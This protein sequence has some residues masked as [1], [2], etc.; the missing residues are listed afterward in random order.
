VEPLRDSPSLLT[1]V[2]GWELD[3]SL[4]STEFPKEAE[5]LFDSLKSAFKLVVVLLK[6]VDA[7]VVRGRVE[8]ER[9]SLEQARKDDGAPDTR[10]DEHSENDEGNERIHVL[11][12]SIRFGLW[13]KGIDTES[14]FC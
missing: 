5:F 10:N 9:V 7:R 11:L 8:L 4:R 3:R 1:E 13:E 12:Q 6:H 2:R 14:W